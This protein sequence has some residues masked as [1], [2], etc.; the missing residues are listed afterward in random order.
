MMEYRISWEME[1]PDGSWSPTERVFLDEPGHDGFDQY[2]TLKRWEE[3][4][5]EPVRNV[6]LEW[7]KP[8]EWEPVPDA[9]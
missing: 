3:A 2:E 9:E 6:K 4:G 5:V 1:N 8:S 7:R